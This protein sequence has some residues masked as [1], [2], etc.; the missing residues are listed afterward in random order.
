[1]AF[2]TII[3]ITR[4]T[5]TKSPDKKYPFSRL[6]IFDKI[7]IKKTDQLLRQLIHSQI[8]FNFVG[9]LVVVVVELP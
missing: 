6:Y 5:T 9:F 1:M 8:S 4:G 7:F 2:I 3:V